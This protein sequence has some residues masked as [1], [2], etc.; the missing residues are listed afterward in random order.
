MENAQRYRHLKAA[1][2]YGL[3]LD[4]VER[5]REE[6]ECDLCGAE[7]DVLAIDHCHQSGR[8][9]G[10]L[11]DPCNTF[12]GRL[13]IRLPELDRYLAYLRGVNPKHEDRTGS[14]A[15]EAD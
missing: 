15:Q 3:R 6:R 4:Q 12:L 2:T 14:Q 7:Q 1:R 9:R 8:V 10:L 13:E 11:C 5:F